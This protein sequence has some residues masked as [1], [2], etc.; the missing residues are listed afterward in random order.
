VYRLMEAGGLENAGIG[1]M[2]VLELVTSGK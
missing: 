1:S 2:S